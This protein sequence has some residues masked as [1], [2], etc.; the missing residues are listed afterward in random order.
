MAGHE[1]DAKLEKRIA[2]LEAAPLRWWAGEAEVVR[3][4]FSN[5]RTRED[6]LHWLKL[7]AARELGTVERL[8]ETLP[9]DLA[10]IEKAVGRDSFEASTRSVYEEARHYRLLA[11]IMEQIAGERPDPK[12]LLALSGC[13]SERRGHPDLPAMSAEIEVTHRLLETHGELAE[14]ALGFS[15][16]AGAAMFYMGNRLLELPYT[17]YSGGAVEKAIA[18]AMGVIFHDEMRHGPVHIPHIARAIRNDEDLA[19]ARHIITEK[20]IAHLRLRNETFGNPLTE[21]RMAEIDADIG[22]EPLPVDY[23][24]ITPI[25]PYS[26]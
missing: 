6:D 3:V 16:G 8:I 18:Q 19:T 1:T 9:A 13:Q 12:E 7:Q 21:A 24:N 11:D 14:V 22:V 26:A 10:R 5:P 15:E 2:V 17:S 4:Y 25:S 23:R 20:A